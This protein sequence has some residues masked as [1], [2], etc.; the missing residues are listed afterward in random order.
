MYNTVIT[1]SLSEQ[2]EHDKLFHMCQAEGDVS[3]VSSKTM[4]VGE[5]EGDNSRT[6]EQQKLHKIDGHYHISFGI[7]MTF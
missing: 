3:I 6:A 1:D 5:W 7:L 2:N 4:K